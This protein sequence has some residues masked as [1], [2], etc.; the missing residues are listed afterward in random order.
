MNNMLFVNIMK[1][2]FVKLLSVTIIAIA[3]TMLAPSLHAQEHG[4]RR[5]HNDEDW[6]NRIMSM[7]ISYLTD[8]LELTPEEAQAFWPIYNQAQE[9]THKAMEAVMSAFW[10]MDKAIKENKSDKE[11]TNLLHK[12]TLALA[13]SKNVEAKYIPQYEKVLSGKKVA[14]LFVGEE[15]FRMK[16]IRRLGGA[17]NPPEG[18]EGDGR[19]PNPKDKEQSCRK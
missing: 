11:I 10:E 1:G 9:E 14:K 4:D 12:Y 18:K 2:N 17:P 15:K 19:N 13:A 6:K 7:K 16:Q 8:E 3:A 5:H